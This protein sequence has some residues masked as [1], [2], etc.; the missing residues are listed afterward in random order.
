[1][2]SSYS[3]QYL[4]KLCSLLEKQFFVSVNNIS[5]INMNSF[6]T[7]LFLS[8]K[9]SISVLQRVSSIYASKGQ[10]KSFSR[11]LWHL[12]SGLVML[13]LRNHICCCLGYAK[14]VRKTSI[15][16]CHKFFCEWFHFPL[17]SENIPQNIMPQSFFF[18]NLLL[19]KKINFN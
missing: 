4:L 5:A 2:N 19:E 18:N 3:F 1:M 9:M 6:W 16:D 12:P 8:P 17:T 13:I 14:R 7:R 11:L 15:S 10:I